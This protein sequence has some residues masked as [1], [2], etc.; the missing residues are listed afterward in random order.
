M[1]L[2]KRIVSIGVKTSEKGLSEYLIKE[3][4]EKY[5][6]RITEFIPFFY[7][8]ENLIYEVK[9]STE[10]EIELSIVIRFF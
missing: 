10:V 1:N 9:V 2:G 6:F 4:I 3:K 7:L 5:C 8:M